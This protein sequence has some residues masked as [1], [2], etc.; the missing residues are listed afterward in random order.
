MNNK[1]KSF[2]PQKESV[3]L[4]VLKDLKEKKTFIKLFF[5]YRV[6]LEFRLNNVRGLF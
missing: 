4:K 3:R 1:L 2:H 6:R 5:L